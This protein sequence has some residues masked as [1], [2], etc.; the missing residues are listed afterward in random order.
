MTRYRNQNEPQGP[1]LRYR[2]NF[3]G[4]IL[5]QPIPKP[6]ALSRQTYDEVIPGFHKRSANGEI[7][8]NPYSSSVN[9]F[10]ASDNYFARGVLKK[11]GK[12]EIA[13]WTNG[14]L[15]TTLCLPEAF[16]KV[17]LDIESA[18]AIAA[19]EAIG[20]VNKTDVDLGNFA[21]EWSKTRSLHRDL[22]NA[23]LK[24]FTEGAKTRSK[25]SSVKKVTLYDQ[26]GNPLLNKSGK[27]R[28]KYI[29]ESA[30]ISGV[31][32][33]NV[34]S[35]ISNL[36]LVGRMGLLPLLSDLEGACK[37]L[38]KKYS[39]RL[40]AR[41]SQTLN[42]IAQAVMPVDDFGG[43]KWAV[44][45]QTTKAWTIRYGILY[46]SSD[47]GRAVAGLGLSRPLTT[48][49]NLLPWSFV[50]DWFLNV[51]AWLDAVQPSLA[52]RNLC[53]WASTSETTVHTAT[54]AGSKT[55]SNSIQDWSASWNGQ[56]VR[57]N[58]VKSR[59]PWTPTVPTLPSPGTG[60][61]AL[62]SFDFAALVLQ[63]LK[64]KI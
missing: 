29:T 37:F 51:G 38:S 39:P 41:G 31:G 7:F 54:V 34:S 9:T 63:R 50:A 42:G 3:D 48:A 28:Y 40:T 16:P 12:V 25:R 43:V 1:G 8:N 20:S 62:R 6:A 55:H 33:T 10:A 44:T 36:Y 64:I 45:L 17:S 61:N 57:T 24:V 32:M 27:P 15:L 22:G 46:E 2:K 19:V 26:Y 21:G 60:F 53:A 18:A 49:W 47:A 23:I 13:N 35:N 52:S 14:A 58:I 4:S 30:E 5:N 59:S 56:L 11:D